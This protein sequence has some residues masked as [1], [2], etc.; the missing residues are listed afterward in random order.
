MKIRAKVV[1]PVV[2]VLLLLSSPLVARAGGTQADR[3]AAENLLFS[4]RELIHGDPDAPG[5]AARIVTLLQAAEAIEPEHPR[6]CRLLSEVYALQ[7]KAEKAAQAVAVCLEAHPQ[8]AQLAS[9]WLA[10]QLAQ[11]QQ[12]QQRA[13]FLKEILERPELSDALKSDAAVQLALIRQGQG[14]PHEAHAMFLRALRL[15]PLSPEAI[16]AFLNLSGPVDPEK[17]AELMIRL[18]VSQPRNQALNL[19]IALML[20]QFGLYGRALEMFDT[21]EKVHAGGD[22]ASVDPAVLSAWCNALLDAGKPRQMLDLVKKASDSEQA[23]EDPWLLPRIEAHRML[24]ESD[25]AKPLID[26]LEKRYRKR[27]SQED[28]SAALATEV[29]W[30]YLTWKPDDKEAAAFAQKASDLQP[31]HPLSRRVLGMSLLAAGQEDKGLT[32]LEPLMEKDAFAAAGVARHFLDA[33][34]SEDAAAAVKAG[35][36]A[37]RSGPGA[38][39]LRSLAA[40]MK[41]QLDPPGGARTA[42]KAFDEATW[43]RTAVVSPER[44]V[45]VTLVPV[46]QSVLPGEPI[47]V[48]AIVENLSQQPLPLGLQGILRPVMKL[49]VVTGSARV[50]DDLP[51]LVWQAPRVLLPE[52]RM[53]TRYRLDIG[54]LGSTLRSMPFARGSLTVTAWPESSVSDQAQEGP[55]KPRLSVEPVVILRR[56]LVSTDSDSPDAWLRAYRRR[57]ADLESMLEQKD[58]TRRLRAGRQVAALAGFS[59]RVELGKAQ[60]PKLLRDVSLRPDARRLLRKA[61][62]NTSPVVRSQVLTDLA[63]LPLSEAMAGPVTA[64]LG[65]PSWLVRMRAVELVGQSRLG[66]RGKILEHFASARHQM[67]SQ[68]ARAFVP[69]SD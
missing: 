65:D 25:K 27:L 4:A 34:R 8:D 3:L 45:R 43:V 50:F 6:T 39:V 9:R 54:D 16:S 69:Q 67:V 55:A 7:G 13:V 37:S 42:A 38:R 19:R 51:P 17:R 29:S 32:L 26:L 62:L 60:M 1:S 56:S 46:D 53:Q 49:R 59:R 66:D 57:V 64:R 11:L 5:R 28:L 31:D 22:V 20:G 14:Q 48:D 10:L 58:L 24:G 30:F 15:D 33:D 36:R 2:F 68:M 12:A 41:L 23:E 18:H 35:A 61:L 40:R 52:A 44:F 63:N 21:I 47:E